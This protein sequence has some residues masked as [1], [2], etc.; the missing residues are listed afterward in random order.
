MEQLTTPR[1]RPCTLFDPFSGRSS[2]PLLLQLQAGRIGR[3][4]P[5]FW[6][7][8][9]S[10]SLTRFCSMICCVGASSSNCPPCLYVHFVRRICVAC[11]DAEDRAFW[12]RSEL[13]D[14]RA[15]QES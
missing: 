11:R 5:I 8:R 14:P 3:S 1:R 9:N 15:T 10:V 2:T 13:H 6:R 7:P 4:Y 12:S